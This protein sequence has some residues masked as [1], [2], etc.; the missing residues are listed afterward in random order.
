MALG[1]LAR[2]KYMGVLRR[3]PYPAEPYRTPY[4][5]HRTPGRYRDPGHRT[6]S[7]HW[8]GLD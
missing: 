6:L 5:R 4:F 7:G 3:N 8:P 1:V 2:V